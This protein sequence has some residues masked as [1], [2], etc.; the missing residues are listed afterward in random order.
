[1]KV[2]ILTLFPEIMEGYFCSSIMAKAVDRGLF[3]YRLINFREFATDKHR[4]CDD[5]P[6]GG[7]A[8]MV[9]KP[10]PLAKALEF[11][12]TGGKRVV[13]PSPSGRLFRQSMAEEFSREEELVIICGRY[14]GLD[15]RIIDSYVDDEVCVGDYV[16]SSG[17]VAAMVIID[18][19]Y[20]LREGIISAESLEEESFSDGLLEYPHYTRPEIFDGE[21]VP[22]ILLSGH[23]EKIHEWRTRQRLEKTLANRPELL[24]NR[25]L[26]DGE[27]RILKELTRKQGNQGGENP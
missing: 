15:Q 26:D 1:M 27:K 11:V 7:G 22:E 19:V 4:T 25:N 21:K 20:R 9:L 17:E 13:F 3:S 23:H 5:A 12:G 18:A 14:E 10:E 24:K 16:L 2:S 8:G 6:Y